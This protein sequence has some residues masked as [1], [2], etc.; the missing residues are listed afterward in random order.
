MR[1]AARRV[2]VDPTGTE[3]HHCADRE[4]VSLHKFRFARIQ[5]V[6]KGMRK[7]QQTAETR[8]LALVGLDST[9]PNTHTPDH[10]EIES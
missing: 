6:R 8:G 1:N 5:S 10:S 3:Q 7:F 2:H 4:T 9:A